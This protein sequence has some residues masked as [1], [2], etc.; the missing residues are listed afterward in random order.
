MGTGGGV[1]P[2][3]LRSPKQSEAS[4]MGS[5]RWKVGR[6]RCFTMYAVQ[7]TWVYAYR[8]GSIYSNDDGDEGV[9]MITPRTMHSK[10]LMGSVVQEPSGQSPAVPLYRH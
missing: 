9:Y 10:F 5:G 4:F 2:T 6:L 8:D 3:L 1:V 7:P